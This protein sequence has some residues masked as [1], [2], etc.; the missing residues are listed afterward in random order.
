MWVTSIDG[1]ANTNELCSPYWQVYGGKSS[2]INN[3]PVIP[4]PIDEYLPFDG[5]VIQ[6]AMAEVYEGGVGECGRYIGPNFNAQ[7]WN[8]ALESRFDYLIGRWK[9][10]WWS[11]TCLWDQVVFRPI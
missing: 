2:E 4:K 3:L 1:V 8:I 5:E 10:F 11:C 9:H 7:C 6:F